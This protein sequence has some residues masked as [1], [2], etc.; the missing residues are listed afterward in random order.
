M[1]AVSAWIVITL[2]LV[3]PVSAIAQSAAAPADKSALPPCPGDP[4]C[5]LGAAPASSSYQ[6]APAASATNA[7]AFPFPQYIPIPDQTGGA[8]DSAS[9]PYL[10]TL[11]SA[12]DASAAF[13]TTSM[14][15]GP[16]PDTPEM[17]QK[18]APL[19]KAGRATRARGN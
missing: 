14:T 4:R 19:S 7:S 15:N 11:S 5:E 9:P 1:R 3:A 10:A 8:P 16:V 6:S 18:Y 17:R 13:S 12:T 2:G